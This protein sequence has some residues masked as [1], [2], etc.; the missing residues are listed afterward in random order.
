MDKDVTI[1]NA[2]IVPATFHARFDALQREYLYIIY[3]YPL[4]SPFIVKRAMWVSDKLDMDFLKD[5]SQYFIGERDFASF[6]KKESDEEN[7]VRRID[8]F[9][10]TRNEE[11]IIF[12]IKGTSFLHNMIRII[13]GTILD[14]YK[15]KRDPNDIIKILEQKDRNAGGITAPAYGLYLNKIIYEPPLSEMESAY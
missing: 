11:F 4:K 9:E 1:K 12:R 14:F 7:T 3:N 5:I 2:F 10:I 15:D 6:C 8:E 13:I